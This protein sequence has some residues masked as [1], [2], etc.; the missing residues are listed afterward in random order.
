MLDYV[1][2]NSSNTDRITI[3][4]VPPV[5]Y[6]IETS[7]PC[8]FFSRVKIHDKLCEYYEKE[9]DFIAANEKYYVQFKP[10]RYEGALWKVRPR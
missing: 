1:G 5:F 9:Y 3:Q 4:H 7:Y 8:Y 6:G 10:F 2:Y